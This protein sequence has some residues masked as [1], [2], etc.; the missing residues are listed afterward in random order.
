MISGNCALQG[1]SIAWS[2]N[3]AS[4]NLISVAGSLTTSGS[5]ALDAT[6]ATAGDP[7]QR[8]LFHATGAIN[9]NA[10]WTVTPSKYGVEA[11]GQNLVLAI[12]P[13]RERSSRSDSRGMPA[14]HR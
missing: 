10:S 3:A 1:G 7:P 4:S 5:I 8:V 12:A 2:T 6:G 11:Q 9:N 13:P 14:Q